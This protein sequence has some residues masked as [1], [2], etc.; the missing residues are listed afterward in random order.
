M[1]ELASLINQHLSALEA[2]AYSPHTLRNRKSCLRHFSAW[3]DDRGIENCAGIS[4]PVLEAY[5]A[6]LFHDRQTNG[7][8]LGASGQSQKLIAIKTFMKW[9]VRTHYLPFNPATEL[10]LPRKSHHLPGAVDEVDAV[11][12]GDHCMAISP[13]TLLGLKLRKRSVA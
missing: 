9:L 4:L 6:T 5:R 7:R 10:E 3:C 13:A 1:S 2:A 8:P 12:R 11:A